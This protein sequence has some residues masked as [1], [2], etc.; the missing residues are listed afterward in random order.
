MKVLASAKECQLTV[1]K[2]AAAMQRGENERQSKAE[3]IFN[4]MRAQIAKVFPDDDFE[5]WSYESE[6]YGTVEITRPETAFDVWIEEHYDGS[7]QFTQLFTRRMFMVWDELE[8]NEFIANDKELWEHQKALFAWAALNIC[9]GTREEAAKIL[10][11]S[12]FGSGKSLINGLIMK[13][14]RDA[15][16]DLMLRQG[17]D[18]KEIPT[19]AFI[20]RRREH[21]E[22]NIGGPQFSVVNTVLPERVDMNM[23]WKDL[24]MMYGEEFTEYCPRPNV[25]NHP[26]YNLFRP[27]NEED[28][29][30]P[31]AERIQAYLES[32]ECGAEGFKKSKKHKEIILTLTK[33]INGDIVLIPD[34]EEVPQE[35]AAQLTSGHVDGDTQILKGDTG[36]AFEEGKGYHVK[37]S[38]KQTA[39]DKERYSTQVNPEGDDQFMF[40]DGSALTRVPENIRKDLAEIALRCRAVFLDE[41]GYYNPDTVSDSMMQISGHDQ[42]VVG[43]TGQDRGIAGREQRDSGGW[44]RSPSISKARMIEMGLMKPIA[45]QNF[46][47]TENAASPGSQEAWQ[48]YRDIMFESVKTA[49]TL[50]L[51]QPHEVDKL[52]VVRAVRV[53]QYAKNIALAHAEMGIPVE[54]YCYHAGLGNKKSDMLKA[55][56]AP[57][58]AGDPVRILVGTD[59]LLSDALTFP[60]VHCI[61]IVDNVSKY[62]RD[63][64]CGRLGHIRNLPGENETPDEEYERSV[65]RTYFREQVLHK[66]QDPYLRTVAAQEGYAEEIPDEGAVHIPLRIMIDAKGYR[67]DFE[68]EDLSDPEP[69]PDTPK[70]RRRKQRVKGAMP[71]VGIPLVLTNSVSLRNE[72]KRLEGQRRRLEKRRLLDA[73]EALEGTRRSE[74]PKQAPRHQSHSVASVPAYVSPLSSRNIR[75]DENVSVEGVGETYQF[76]INPSEDTQLNGDE[77]QGDKEEKKKAKKKKTPRE[78]HV[79]IIFGDNGQPT[80]GSA[81]ALLDPYDATSLTPSLMIFV[82]ECYR[83]GLRGQQ[84]ADAVF[85]RAVQMGQKAVE[86]REAS[87][88]LATAKDRSNY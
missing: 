1:P 47:D 19:G 31:V 80:R 77:K 72:M 39:T 81:A 32:L 56:N 21:V 48:Q 6:N 14:F 2:E 57:K 83:D 45:Y 74:S 22:Q 85:R 24:S 70:V 88:L 58:K 71:F 11:R 3:K 44:N 87:E 33:L 35:R 17:K 68:W 25:V 78:V 10:L 12:P 23:H 69:L 50:G 5:A 38:S 49:E 67:E 60:N 20:A 9:T 64:L 65:A 52:V 30:P 15:Q 40:V 86:R 59:N 36:F 8:K 63:Q 43:I 26:F 37:T 55:F 27:Q 84:L 16:L 62:S 76:T 4:A 79:A 7:D 13:A 51:P 41:A 28:G 82:S 73:L 29:F 42:I 61:D 34:F 75:L 53:H 66:G 54:V 46:G 18:H